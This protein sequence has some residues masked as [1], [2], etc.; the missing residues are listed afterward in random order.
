[1]Q[2]EKLL[3]VSSVKSSYLLNLPASLYFRKQGLFTSLS[4]GEG[5]RGISMSDR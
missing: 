4:N 5:F 2:E 1:M 3:R